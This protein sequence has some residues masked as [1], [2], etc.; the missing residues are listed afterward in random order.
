MAA[1]LSVEDISN[2]TGK[3]ENAVSEN[4]KILLRSHGAV[5]GNGYGRPAYRNFLIVE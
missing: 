4:L 5:L 3:L 2:M 1:L